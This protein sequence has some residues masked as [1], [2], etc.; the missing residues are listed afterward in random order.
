M[1]RL[2]AASSLWSIVIRLLLL[3]KIPELRNKIIFVLGALV[4]FRIGAVVPVPGV[5]QEAL[6]RFFSSN[7]LFG[8]LNI[9]TGGSLES[10]SIVML[11]VGPYITA[12]IIM[13]LLTMIFPRLK[14]IYYEEGE[15]GRQRFNQ[16]SRMATVP[17]AIL[18][19][20]G[21]LVLL[22]SQ[23]VIAPLSPLNLATHI[24]I[25]TAGTVWLMWIGELI[26]EKGIGN[27]VSLIIFAGIIAS[28]PSGLART[29]QTYEGPGDLFGYGVF[30]AVALIVIAGVVFI[31][32]AQRN[33]PVN[34]AK[35][36]RG[37]RM[38]GGVAAHLPIR[39]NTAGVIPIIFALSILLFPSMMATFL[40]NVK[41]A[42]IG[43][44]ADRLS[45]ILQNEWV[46][47]LFYFVLVFVFTYF[48]TSVIFDPKEIA[49][50][51]QK[52][53]GYMPGIRPGAATA[54][55]LGKVVNRTTLAGALF[56]GS[57]AV[58]PSLMR[59]FMPSLTTLTI[60]GTAVLIVVSVVLETMKQINAQLSMREYEGL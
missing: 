32:E 5:N 27:G 33:I 26:S 55:F 21:F 12:T 25:I 46:Y 31:N 16:I 45:N 34:Y 6:A 18:Q 19:S 39:V 1:S 35:R 28:I 50:N 59:G 8:L 44:F 54:Q 10:L 20:Y 9:F 38:Y 58:F 51:L 52:Q 30:A 13:Q 40:V 49:Q 17:L 53:G 14:Q 48:Y 7:E 24:A 57:I 60:G 56:L 43:E 15:Q 29:I 11:G 37:M 4:V 36:V 22:Q 41:F 42:K 2:P 47:S 3:W 23:Q